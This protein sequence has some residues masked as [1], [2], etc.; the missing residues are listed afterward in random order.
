[1]SP[2]SPDVVQSRGAASSAAVADDLAKSTALGA[3]AES[4]GSSSAL[5]EWCPAWAEQLGDAYLSGTSCVFLL[6]GNVRDSVPI[7]P[8]ATRDG[9]PDMAS[10]GSL[11]EFLAREMFG[12]WDIVLAYDVGRGLRP[13]AGND[14]VRLREMAQ[15]LSERLGNASGWPREPEAAIGAI[16]AILERNLIDPTEQR[17]RI[18]VVLDYAQYLVPAGDGGG[19]A[20]AGAGRLVRVLS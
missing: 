10:W 16:D 20:R 4:R 5:P 14:A 17:K 15:W 2:S 19:T 3:I 7:A 1:M 11:P 9:A 18:A 8:P 6:H 12:R 13:L